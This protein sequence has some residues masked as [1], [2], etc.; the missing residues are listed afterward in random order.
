MHSTFSRFEGLSV[1]A[2][3]DPGAKIAALQP[4]PT[5]LTSIR[6]PLYSI[7]VIFHSARP[8]HQTALATRVGLDRGG[9]RKHKDAA[10]YVEFASYIR[11]GRSE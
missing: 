1:N 2:R 6:Y 8:T 10:A 7:T 11:H 4:F 3:V 9:R 5:G